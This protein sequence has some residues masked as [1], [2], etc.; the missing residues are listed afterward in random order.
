MLGMR[1]KTPGSF[2]TRQF[3]IWRLGEFVDGKGE[4]MTLLRDNDTAIAAAGISK[5]CRADKLW[6]ASVGRL[7][8]EYTQVSEPEQKFK[9]AMDYGNEER[10]MESDQQ[11]LLINLSIGDRPKTS[12]LSRVVCGEREEDITIESLLYHIREDPN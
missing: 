12:R 11:G 9:R 5:T 1:A 4:S 3:D 8:S 2:W 6:I 7:W 10:G